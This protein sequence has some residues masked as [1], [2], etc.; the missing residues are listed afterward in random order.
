M[1]SRIAIVAVAVLLGRPALAQS[2]PFEGIWQ[3]IKNPHSYFSIQ[4]SGTQVVLVDLAELERRGATLKAAYMGEISQDAQ[5]NPVAN[6]VV[7]DDIGDMQKSAEVVPRSST[8]LTIY[9]CMQ[10][11]GS[12]VIGI[13]QHLQKVF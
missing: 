5:G 12:C 11:T 1:I 3:D 13:L 6:L 7:L 2:S 9:W 4:I 10:K 8:E